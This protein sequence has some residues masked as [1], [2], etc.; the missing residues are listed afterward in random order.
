MYVVRPTAEEM[1]S[2]VRYRYRRSQ[3]HGR[4]PPTPRSSAV[5]P[6]A[7]RARHAAGGRGGRGASLLGGVQ[8]R[9]GATGRDRRGPGRGGGPLRVR[10]D[11][12]RG[13]AAA[14]PGVGRTASWALRSPT[15]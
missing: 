12:V 8:A 9:P 15:T 5:R 13:D 14:G 3:L 4:T 6:S 1:T 2:A 7:G 11:R 10:P